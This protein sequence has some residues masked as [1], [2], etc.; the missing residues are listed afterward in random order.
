MA[1]VLSADEAYD[2]DVLALIGASAA[3]HIAEIPFLKVVGAVRMG[4]VDGQLVVMPTHTDMETSDLDLIVAGH[5]DGV[6]MIEGFAREL[7]EADMSNAI[8]DAHKQTLVIA[9]MI[10]EL[11]TKTNKPAKTLPPQIPDNPL[12]D[13]LHA[14]YGAEFRANYLT[15]GK[16]ARYAALDEVKKKIVAAYVPEGTTDNKYTASQVGGAIGAMKERIFREITLAGTRID[17]RDYAVVRGLSSEVG[18]VPRV[19]GSALFQRGETQALV[20]ATLGTT[21]DEQKVDGLTPGYSKKFML[22]YNF[23]PFS[24][25]ECKPIRGPGRR[26]IGHGMLAERIL[27]AV[28]PPPT[29]FPYTIRLVSEILESNG[30]SIDGLG[31]RRDARPHGRRRADQPA[32]SPAFASA[33]CRKERPVRPPHRHP[34]RRRPLRRHGLQGGRH[35]EAASP[36]SSSTS[37]STASTTNDRPRRPRPGPDARIEILKTMLATLQRRARRSANSPRDCCR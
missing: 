6:C 11:R 33:S 24:V 4:R 26:E 10:E 3:L 16:L 32:R 27:K 17:G 37:R 9:S 12:A 21:Q 15:E 35:A 20:V 36:A 31:L 14:K 5:K 13:E 29:K 18:V 8:L 1:Q 28:L 34:G 23:P 7:P 30:S 22:D 2:P 25:G 19:H